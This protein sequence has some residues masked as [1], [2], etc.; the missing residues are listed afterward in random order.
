M[1]LNIRRILISFLLSIILIGVCSK[2]VYASYGIKDSIKKYVDKDN[3]V[4]SN[5]KKIIEWI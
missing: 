3:L 4:I 2:F 1:G 5:F